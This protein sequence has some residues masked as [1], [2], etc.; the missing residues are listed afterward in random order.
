MRVT[1][2]MLC[3]QNYSFYTQKLLDFCKDI[4][5]QYTFNPSRPKLVWAVFKNSVRIPKKTPD[6]TITKMNRSMLFKEMIPFC[7]ETHKYKRQRYWWYRCYIQ[8]PL[9]LKIKSSKKG[10]ILMHSKFH[11]VDLGTSKSRTYFPAFNTF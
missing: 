2:S 9:G 5:E 10:N 6:S 3:L 7:T 8:I 4:K 1:C 11:I